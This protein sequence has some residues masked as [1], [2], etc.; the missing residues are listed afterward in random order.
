MRVD[1][2]SREVTQKWERFAYDGGVTYLWLMPKG[3]Y[4][5]KRTS[6]EVRCIRNDSERMLALNK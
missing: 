1:T 6:D 4:E 3:Q 5:M 2:H